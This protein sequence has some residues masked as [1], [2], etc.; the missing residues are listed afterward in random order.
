MG[1]TSSNSKR[2]LQTRHRISSVKEIPI[3]SS[4]FVMLSGKNFQD[5]YILGK[6]ISSSH[7]CEIRTVFHRDTREERAVKV[8]RKE[9]FSS[10]SYNKLKEEINIVKNIDHPNIIRFF[11]IFE[12]PTRTFV[13]ME[14]CKGGELFEQILKSQHFSESQA[15]QIMKELFSCLSYL[16]ERNIIHRDIKPENVLLEER[17]NLMNIKLINFASSIII[18]ENRKIKGMVG[19]AYYIAPEVIDGEYNEKCDLWSSGVVLYMLLSSTPPFDGISDKEILRS[20]SESQISFED[21][22]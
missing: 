7:N 9:M 10:H 8:Y 16:H 21:A 17:G 2:L 22:S 20:V 6:S 13:V 19:T 15:A 5:V 1:C 3:D 12:E 4:T 14:Q 11:E 18:E